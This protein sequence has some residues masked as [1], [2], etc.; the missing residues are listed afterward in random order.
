[1]SDRDTK[2]QNSE[3]ILRRLL[4]LS[5][6]C[7]Q[8]LYGD[9][10]EMQC[11]SCLIDFKRMPAENIERFLPKRTVA[12]LVATESPTKPDADDDSRNCDELTIDQCLTGLD[13]FYSAAGGGAQ[14]TAA[15][16]IIAASAD[17]LQRLSIRENNL[18]LQ[19]SNRAKEI[20]R[21]QEALF[22]LSG[23]PWSVAAPGLQAYALDLLT[24]GRAALSPVQRHQLRMHLEESPDDE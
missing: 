6:R 5:H 3:L 11:A 15:R 7:E 21:L 12:K 9:D 19:A 2:P 4:W 1:M 24:S 20:E 13:Q 23:P 8:Q 14:S 10:G 18:S 16:E 17:H 22:A